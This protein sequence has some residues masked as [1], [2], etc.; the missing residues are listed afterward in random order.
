MVGLFKSMLIYTM[1]AAF[2][3][4]ARILSHNGHD[5]AQLEKE[6]KEST[7]NA[8]MFENIHYLFEAKKLSVEEHKRLVNMISEGMNVCEL[9]AIDRAYGGSEEL[10]DMYAVAIRKLIAQK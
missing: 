2:I 1:N 5:A 7:I 6:L 10:K 3:N 4:R 9:Q 8:R